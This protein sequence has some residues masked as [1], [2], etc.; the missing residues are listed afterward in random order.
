MVIMAMVMIMDKKE[1]DEREWR[2]MHGSAIWSNGLLP[3]VA[4]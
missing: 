2:P 1:R 3:H 4:Q